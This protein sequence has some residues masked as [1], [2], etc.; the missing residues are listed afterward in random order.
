MTEVREKATVTNQVAVACKGLTKT[1]GAVHALS[2]VS[3]DINKGSVHSLVGENGAGKSTCL[4]IIAGRLKPTTG[5]VEL[6]GEDLQLGDPRAARKAGIAAIYQ[7]LTTLPGLSTQANLFVGEEETRFGFLNESD[8]RKRLKELCDRM[9]VALPA[10]TPAGRLSVAD[11]QMLEIMRALHV[12]PDVI[13]FDEPTASLSISERKTLLTVMDSLRQQGKTLVLVSHNLDEVLSIS[14]D[15]TVFRDGRVAEKE[16]N[17]KWDKERLVRAMLGGT[18]RASEVAASKVPRRSKA[19]DKEILRVEDL[20]VPGVIEGVNFSL[21]AGEL[22]GIAGLVGSGR[23]TILRSLIGLEPKASG[24]IWRNG[25][26]ISLPKS[27]RAALQRGLGLI[28][29]DRKLTGLI[30]NQSAAENIVLPN[31]AGSSRS[32]IIGP[33]SAR[34]AAKQAAEESAFDT[35]RLNALARQLS[36]GNQQKLLFARWFYRPVE[37]LL[38]DEPMRGVDIGAK[39]DIGGV[40]RRHADSGAAVLMVSSELEEIID[41]CSR[42]IV[43]SEGKQVAEFAEEDDITV[44]TILNEAFRVAEG[45]DPGR[46]ETE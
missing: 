21:H 37:I 17:G 33:G 19:S 38:A 43:L 6:F 25:E 8:M 32:G 41:L 27:P 16:H 3:L 9:G 10:D 11:Q 14:D 30:A 2:E 45:S 40:L 13:L 42:V 44:N 31:I 1:F 28:P 46:E 34:R 24:R 36:G 39:A 7:E 26:E 5:S 22:M 23:T 29:E 15:V 12:N 35:K 4:G 20:T 18:A